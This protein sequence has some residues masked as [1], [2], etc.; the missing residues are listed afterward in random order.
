M[1]SNLEESRYTS[2]DTLWMNDLNPTLNFLADMV[3]CMLAVNGFHGTCL[4]RKDGSSSSDHFLQSG[5]TLRKILS[6]GYLV[7]Q[8]QMKNSNLAVMQLLLI[9]EY[10]LLFLKLCHAIE[11]R[12]GGS[13]GCLD[14]ISRL[15]QMGPSM[16]LTSSSSPSLG[17]ASHPP[18]P[19]NLQKAQARL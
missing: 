1:L 10:L 19:F 13:V 5:H 16:K 9:F 7:G 15:L 3:Q 17:L 4:S 11:K 12:S 2:L 14:Q 8:P 18:L 6:K